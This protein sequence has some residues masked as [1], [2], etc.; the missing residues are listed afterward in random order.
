MGAIGQRAVDAITSAIRDEGVQ[1]RAALADLEQAII[2][3]A[4][5]A[6]TE[7]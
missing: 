7:D 1:T 2:T 5:G 3:R 6:A 4:T